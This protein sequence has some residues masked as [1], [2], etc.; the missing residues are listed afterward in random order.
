MSLFHKTIEEIFIKHLENVSALDKDILGQAAIDDNKLAKI[1]KFLASFIQDMH[2]TKID[3]NYFLKKDIL[4]IT[5]I[6]EEFFQYIESGV[7]DINSIKNGYLNISSN[8]KRIA[9]NQ[10]SYD[11]IRDIKKEWNKKADKQFVSYITTIHWGKLDKLDYVIAQLDRKSELSCIGYLGP[12]YACVW[13]G[14][15]GVVIRGTITLAGNRDL[16]SDAY[17][18]KKRQVGQ[19]YSDAVEVFIYDKET[20]TTPRGYSDTSTHNEFILDNWKVTAIIIDSKAFGEHLT[21]DTFRADIYGHI[22][23]LCKKYPELTMIK[24]AGLSEIISFLKQYSGKF[25][26]KFID[27]MGKEL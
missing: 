2:S 13:A 8:I 17:S 24:E 11:K 4:D 25:R 21:N 27:E 3:P 23:G 15:A 1:K 12:P 26:L 14:Y 20:F 7:I 16:R 5:G 22:S 6:C 18:A 9:I 10:S 19:K